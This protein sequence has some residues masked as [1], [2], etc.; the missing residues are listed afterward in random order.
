[1]VYI[2]IP[3]PDASDKIK[4]LNTHLTNH[5]VYLLVYMEGCGPCN[6]TRP[7]WK[8][9]GSTFGDDKTVVVAS[10]NKDAFSMI[11]GAG[12]S[13]AGFPTMRFIRG[14]FIEEYEGARDAQS[15]TNW[16]KRD[17]GLQ[18][19]GRRKL[20]RQTRGGSRKKRRNLSRKRGLGKRKSRA[21][22]R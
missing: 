21:S 16:V 8:K 14:D 1:M 7:E 6:A 3:N 22:W 19:G 20:S 11:T 18:N 2:E 12:D 10:V 9:M 5:P 15:L 17:T 4:T 13:P